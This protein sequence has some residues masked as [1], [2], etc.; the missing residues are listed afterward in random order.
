MQ[1]LAGN[2]QAHQCWA[3]K[4]ATFALERDVVESDRPLVE[5]LGAKSLES[6]GSLKQVMLALVQTDAFR[7]RVGGAK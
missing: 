2:A 1:D 5:A 4:M 3:K 6:G 7:T